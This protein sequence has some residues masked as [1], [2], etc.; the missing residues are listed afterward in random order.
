MEVANNNK[1]PFIGMELIKIGKQ[2]KTCVYKKTTNKGLLLHCQSHVDARYKRFLLMTM[3]KRAHC[4]LS[5]PDLFAEEC[6]NWKGI[7]LRLKYPENRIN[8]TITR[9]IQPQVGD[10]QLSAPVRTIL[11]F[12]DQKSA[13]V[14]RRQLSDVGKKINSDLRPVFTSKKIA[15]DIK[16]ADAKP[17]SVN[18]Q[19]VIYE[20][21]CDPCDADCIGYTCQHLFQRIEEH[22]HSAIG[23][24][25]RDAHNQKNKDLREQFTILKKCRGKFECLIYEM[26]FIQQNKPE[27][28]TQSDS[29]KAKLFS[30]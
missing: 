29:I 24:Y 20:F 19:C 13:D 11:P 9:F 10:V 25:L 30:T 23:K 15:N 26:L 5:S 4:L 1:L 16:V 2:L 14:V 21:K 17:P 18:Q 12:K 28:N 7:F 8:S 3:L 27:L 6:D 22:K